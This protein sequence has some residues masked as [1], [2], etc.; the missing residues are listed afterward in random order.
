MN[1]PNRYDLMI[2]MELSPRALNEFDNS[3]IHKEWKEKFGK[4]I[5][6]KTIFDCD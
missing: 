6:S 5:M 1:L 2:K 4:Y 3:D